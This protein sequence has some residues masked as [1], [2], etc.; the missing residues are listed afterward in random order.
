MLGLLFKLFYSV[1]RERGFQHVYLVQEP[2][3]GQLLRR[4]FGL[5]FQPMGAEP[6]TF[7]DGTRVNVDGAPVASLV[8]SLAATGRLETYEAFH[9]AREAPLD[10]RH[11]HNSERLSPNRVRAQGFALPHLQP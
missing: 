1:V 4:G 3:M 7:A 6:H 5:D 2:A 10:R 8:R 11:A 9:V